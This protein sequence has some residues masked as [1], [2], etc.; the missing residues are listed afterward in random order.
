MAVGTIG[1]EKNT[2]QLSRK[3]KKEQTVQRVKSEFLKQVQEGVTE[4]EA[5]KN[6]LKAINEKYNPDKDMF[7]TCDTTVGSSST[8]IKQSVQSV[9]KPNPETVK[10]WLEIIEKALPVILTCVTAVENFVDWLIE[11]MAPKEENA[12]E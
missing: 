5:F 3:E 1:V 2:P 8:M 7:C 9:K 11:K 12:V 10:V 6:S 4:K